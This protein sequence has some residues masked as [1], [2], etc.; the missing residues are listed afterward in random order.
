MKT[1]LPSLMAGI[2][3]FA[4]CGCSSLKTTVS[5]DAKA[6]FAALKNY[7]W[8]PF[9]AVE[10]ADARLN[11]D[12]LDQTI[13]DSVNQTLQKKGFVP[14]ADNSPDFRVRWYVAIDQAAS[15]TQV[16]QFHGFQ[17][18]GIGDYDADGQWIYGPALEEGYQLTYTVGSVVLD[19][20]NAKTG[21]LIWRGAAHAVVNEKASQ[22][23]RRQNIDKALQKIL[24]EF[25]PGAKK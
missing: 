10:R 5:F 25:P 9:P 1:M 20:V 16:S 24:Q 23:Q 21:K 15:D 3:A 2:V 18:P 13:R 12:F 22:E 8:I 17:G 6:N 4:I 19:F 14:A 11:Y 7:S